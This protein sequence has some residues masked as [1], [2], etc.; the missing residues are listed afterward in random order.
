MSPRDVGAASLWEFSAALEGWTAAHGG[1]QKPP[2]PD[3]DE[4]ERLMRDYG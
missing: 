3:E 4:H 1:P 2:P